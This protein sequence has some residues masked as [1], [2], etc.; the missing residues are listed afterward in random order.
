MST[1]RDYK[2]MGLAMV[3]VLFVPSCRVSAPQDESPS[4]VLYLEEVIPPCTP[5]PDSTQNPC[6]LRD[7][8]DPVLGS[9][10]ER[11]LRIPL[12]TMTEELLGHDSPRAVPHIVIRGTVISDTTRC[13]I[14][15]WQKLSTIALEPSKLPFPLHEGF[16][17]YCFVDMRINEYIVGEGPPQLTIIIDLVSFGLTD[18]ENWENI[19]DQWIDGLL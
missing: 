19:T 7:L 10:T 18:P 4:P 11:E 9:H 12:P 5:T 3:L 6:D 13:D 2:I 15:P 14:F 8:P 17:L 1:L 16:F